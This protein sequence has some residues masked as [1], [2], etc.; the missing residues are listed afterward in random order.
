[1]KNINEIMR[2]KVTMVKIDRL[3]HEH[4]VSFVSNKMISEVLVNTCNRFLSLTEKYKNFLLYGTT[5]QEFKGLI[6]EICEG[7]ITSDD[8]TIILKSYHEFVKGHIKV[9]DLLLSLIHICR[10]RRIERCRS[11]WSPDH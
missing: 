8:S 4:S 6:K 9:S 3:L 5:L 11:R 10:C 1:M 2:E 7:P